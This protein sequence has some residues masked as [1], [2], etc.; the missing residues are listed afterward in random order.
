MLEIYTHP[1]HKSA[2]ENKSHRQP[3][4]KTQNMLQLS[5]NEGFGNGRGHES[6]QKNKV[7]RHKLTFK[8]VTFSSPY[9]SIHTE[10]IQVL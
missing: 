5:T 6:R 2:P 10:S 8:L 3:L 4:A 7:S 1:Y 9:Y